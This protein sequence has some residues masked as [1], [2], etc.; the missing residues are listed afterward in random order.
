[1]VAIGRCLLRCLYCYAIIH[2]LI[3]Y[4][5]VYINVD[6]IPFLIHQFYLGMSSRT[7]QHYI[8]YILN[9]YTIKIGAKFYGS[10]I[11]G[12]VLLF[13]LFA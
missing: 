3:L 5:S 4:P 2:P 6:N 11:Y 13:L 7:R 12:K 9:S 8:A 1:M 10:L